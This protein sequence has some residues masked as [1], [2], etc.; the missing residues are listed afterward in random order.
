MDSDPSVEDEQMQ[1]EKP[2][3]QK[4]TVQKAET[5]DSNVT[6]TFYKEDHTLGNLLR[7]TLIKNKNVEFVAYT[8]PHPSEPYMNVRI[9]S[10]SKDKE[11]KK[12][13]RHSLKIISK[14]SDVMLEKF[15][16]AFDNFNR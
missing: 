14:Q 10:V 7:N 2:K 6:F 8:V 1:E 4:L 3:L 5:D 16:E 15:N 12:L 13:L 11:A 9:Q